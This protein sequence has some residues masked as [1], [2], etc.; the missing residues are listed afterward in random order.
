MIAFD[1]EAYTNS[2]HVDG[3][4]WEQSTEM[5]QARGS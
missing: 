3:A 5:E 2:V 1:P 4:I